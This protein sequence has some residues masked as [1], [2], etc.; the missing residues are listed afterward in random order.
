MES[1]LTNDLAVSIESFTREK[2]LGLLPKDSS[3]H[4]REKETF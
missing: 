4:N 1:A 3:R 2:R